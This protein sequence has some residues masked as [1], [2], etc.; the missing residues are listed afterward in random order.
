MTH[1]PAARSA[2]SA[3]AARLPNSGLAEVFMLGRSTDAID[4]AIGTPGYPE[5]PTAMIEEA[6]R[7]M[8][9]G[10]NQ[11]ENPA[12]GQLLRQRIAEMLGAPTDADTEITVTAGATEALYLALLATIDPGDEVVV[13]TPGFDQF[14]AAIELVGGIPR[15]VRLEAPEWRFDSATL[16][17]AFTARTRAVV[18]NTPGNPTGRVLTHDELAELAELC[19]RWNV[20]VISDEVYSTYVF[21]GRRHLSVA[22]VPGLAERSIVVGSLSKSHAVSGWRLGFLRADPSRT[23]VL[24][25]VHQLT[26]LG[27]AAPL[28]HA[29]GL[30]IP[31]VD[32]EAVA[33]QMSARR[34]LAQ[35]IFSRLGMKFAPVEGGCYLFADIGPLTGGRRNSQEF[36][37]DLVDRCRVLV[38][39]GGAFFADPSDGDQYVRIAFNRPA[40][41]LRTAERQLLSV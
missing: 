38:V 28:Q 13:F 5:T 30:A 17:A 6:S 16:A 15:F 35:D 34:D 33:A 10:H 24:Q 4:L 2:V 25:R 22:D 41:T 1:Y 37:R 27:T 26:T 23:Q 19:E 39:P 40:E 12:G 11:Y 20:T 21:D 3:R 31:S 18:L 36:M 32:R 29:A 9:A 14:A 8:R 7:A